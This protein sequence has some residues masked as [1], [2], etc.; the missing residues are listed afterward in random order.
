[1]DNIMINIENLSYNIKDKKIL[2]NIS[3]NACKNKFIGIIGANGSGKTTML[4]HLY[5]A[6]VPP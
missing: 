2:E 3:F 6:I 1:M 4:K 5:N